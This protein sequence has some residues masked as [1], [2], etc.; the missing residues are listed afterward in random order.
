MK[1]I[2]IQYEANVEASHAFDLQEYI[3]TFT[4][5]KSDKF[6]DDRA[7]FYQCLENYRNRIHY[8]CIVRSIKLV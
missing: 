3:G 6:D 8:G 1:D 7:L 5:D 2:H 4:L